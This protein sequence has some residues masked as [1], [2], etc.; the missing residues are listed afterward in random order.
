MRI[1]LSWSDDV[2]IVQSGSS[3]DIGP[4]Y[5]RSGAI[6]MQSVCWL[7]NQSRFVVGAK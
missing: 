2:V 1:L 6:G 4:V 7:V 5:C 3:F